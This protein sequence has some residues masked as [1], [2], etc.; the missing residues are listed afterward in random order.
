MFEMGTGVL[1]EHQSKILPTI[2][3]EGSG[4]KNKH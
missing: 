3:L 4:W 1:N 2:E